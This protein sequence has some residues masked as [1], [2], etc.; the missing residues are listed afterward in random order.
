MARYDAAGLVRDATALETASSSRVLTGELRL[1][2][3]RDSGNGFVLGSYATVS[4]DWL[5]HSTVGRDGGT[6]LRGIGNRVVDVALF[7]EATL[8]LGHGLMATMGLRATYLDFSGTTIL[9]GG[10]EQGLAVEV[11]NGG[12][13][14]FL[15]SAAL[16]WT[17][18]PA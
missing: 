1:A 15:P 12:D 18:S 3:H 17:G 10:R 16:R 13:V 14:T 6:V 7:G 9:P 11:P 2:R 4:D 5:T 8:A